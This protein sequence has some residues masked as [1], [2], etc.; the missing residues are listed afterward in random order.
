MPETLWGYAGDPMLAVSFLDVLKTTKDFL[1]VFIGFSLV[2]FVH[3][4]G[5]FLAAKLCNVKIDRFAVG[6]LTTL[7]SYRKG[8][9]FR[10]GSSEKEYRQRL[11]E[12]ARQARWK[13]GDVDG[14]WEPTD[15]ELEQ[16]GRQLGLG[17]TEYCFNALPLGGYVKMLGQEDF[18]IDK[19]GELAVKA[20]PR[21]FTHKPVG[22][23]MFIVSSGVLMNLV[24]AAFVFMLVFMWGMEAPSAEVGTVMPDSPAH[25]A[26]LQTGDIITHIR[27]REIADRQDLI[28]AIALSKPYEP[29]EVTFRRKDPAT[30]EW[31]THMLEVRPETAPGDDQVKIG[32]GNPMTT[33]IVLSAPDPLLPPEQQLQKDDKIVAVAGQ[34]VSDFTAVTYL[35]ANAGGRWVEMTVERAGRQ[36]PVRARSRLM[37][38]ATGKVG[39]QDE[40]LLG[41]VPRRQWSEI[42]DPGVD[43]STDLRRGDVIVRW[44]GVLAPRMS[45][46]KKSIADHPGS[47]IQVVVLRGGKEE[48]VAVHTKGRSRWG[49]APVEP[50]LRAAFWAQEFGPPVVADIVTEV[51]PEIKTPAAAL[52]ELMP[53]GSRLTRINDQP[54]E[55]WPE[56]LCQF[57]EL[58]G[59]DVKLS[60]VYAQ[61]PEQS[62]TIHIPQT[63]DT[64]LRLPFARMIVSI[65]GKNRVEVEDNGRTVAYDVN[66]SIGQRAALKDLIG[67][68]VTVEYASL[69]EP[70]TKT[71]QVQVT[72]E[73]LDNW[74]ARI[75]TKGIG[76]GLD[77][78][79]MPKLTLVQHRNPL[80]A[81]GVGVMKTYYFIE[82]VIVMMDRMV[83]TRSVGMDQVAG[84]VG[85]VKMGGGMASLGLVYLLYFLALISANLAVINFMPL[86][87]MDGG[88]FVF[89]LIEKIKGKPISLRVQV[90]TQLIG[91]VLIVGIFLI[92]TIK[93]I[94]NW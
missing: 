36:V 48:L 64:A 58:A 25:R 55:S 44:G 31:K 15:N 47:E 46:I 84:P 28:M 91:L 69:L 16:A 70:G 51:T 71:G 22:Q 20:H 7:A 35:T 38:E 43:P 74:T 13:E 94:V 57:V 60:W 26:G 33:K 3:E 23:R 86:P 34:P 49:R 88:L 40:N 14:E 10:W 45:E 4:C 85:I 18:A 1:L 41:L 83:V 12:Q 50:L 68:T 92:V 54:V 24:F 2:I 61:T 72:A 37:F 6:F 19:S 90:A 67:Q 63:V 5:H 80:K 21:A 76:H 81:M 59:Q 42:L 65:A 79:P 27:G 89:L 52:K 82:S 77:V 78:V 9:G 53:R 29:A 39:E 93:D 75:D 56:V 17:E 32:V 87:I 66:S 8:L 73:M 30:G 62:A 11:Q